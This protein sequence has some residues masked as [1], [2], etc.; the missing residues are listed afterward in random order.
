METLLIVLLA[1]AVILAIVVC[2]PIMISVDSR[3]RQV[4]VRWLFALEFQTP[5]PGAAGQKCFTIFRRPV[6]FR[7]RQLSA[8]APGVKKKKPAKTAAEM[9][10]VR[11]KRRATGR[12]VARCLGD[13]A[14]RRALTR[15]FSTLLRRIFRSANLTRSDIEISTPD[16]A[17][18]GMLAGVLT[19]IKPV[20]RSGARVNFRGEN[21]L[22]VELHFQPHRVLKALLFFLTGLPHRALF[23]QWRS[24]AAAQRH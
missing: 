11:A 19:S 13:S 6:P 22:F 16:P 3:N 15:Q 18:N 20:D 9:P 7:G 21:S 10:R 12:F 8:E 2:S 23:R 4:R 5:L 24:F 14:I 1:I 17:L